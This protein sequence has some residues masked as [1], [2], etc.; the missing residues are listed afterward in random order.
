VLTRAY[1]S[2]RNG[3]LVV[4]MNSV[5]VALGFHSFLGV[6]FRACSVAKAAGA[7]FKMQLATEQAL[8]RMS[9]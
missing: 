3:V 5:G 2:V 1:I 9:V 4:H 7:K 6:W 8:R